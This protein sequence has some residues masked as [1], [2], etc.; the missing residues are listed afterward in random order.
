MY[1]KQKAPQPLLEHLLWQRTYRLTI[2]FLVGLSWLLE[3]GIE[4]VGP[5]SH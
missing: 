2:P 3:L 5:S 1:P 4:N